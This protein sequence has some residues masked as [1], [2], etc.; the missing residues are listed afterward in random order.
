MIISLEQ[1][2]QEERRVRIQI[3]K[4]Y[5]KLKEKYDSLVSQTS[6][7][8]TPNTNHHGSVQL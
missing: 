8:K 6:N 1:K 5:H 2:L 7:N 3:E 4:E